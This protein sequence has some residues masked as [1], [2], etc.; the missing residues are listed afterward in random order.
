MTLNNI[1]LINIAKEYNVHLVGVY[2]KSDLINIK[3]KKNGRYIVNLES[4]IAGNRGSHWVS[5]AFGND[6]RY[7]YYFDSFG[8]VPPNEIIRFMQKFGPLYAYNKK[9]IQSLDSVYC[10]YFCIYLFIHM[11]RFQQEAFYERC[12]SY[13]DLFLD[14]SRNIN[15]IIIRDLF[16]QLPSKNLTV[17][18]NLNI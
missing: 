18:Q 10:G 16:R 1:E 2:M 17:R 5:I 15:D 6:K 7:V 13:S 8:S 14:F 11:K 3:P 9:E 12:N 4:R